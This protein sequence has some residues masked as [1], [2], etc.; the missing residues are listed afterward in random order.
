MYLVGISVRRVEN[1]TVVLWDS[2]GS[3]SIINELNQEN[4]KNI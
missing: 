1:L 3:S 4:Y 2:W